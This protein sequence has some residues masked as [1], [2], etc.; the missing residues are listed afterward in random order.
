MR[1]RG[2]VVLASRNPGKLAELAVLAGSAL[3]LRLLPS[4]SPEIVEDGD[5]YLANALIKAQ[6][7]ARLTGEPSL[8]DDSGLE[9]D[10]LGGAPGIHSA[11]FGGPGLDDAGRCAL[12]LQR[13]AGMAQR[14][15]RFRCVLV[16]AQGEEWISAEGTVEGEIGLAPVGTGG[17]GYDPLFRVASLGGRTLAEASEGEKNGLSHRAVAMRKLLAMLREDAA[18]AASN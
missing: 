15:A 6:T 9:V 14:S 10:A 4:S 18:S 11:R 2:P 16:L 1:V 7:I 12:L 13:L 8:A 3:K 5:T 17:F